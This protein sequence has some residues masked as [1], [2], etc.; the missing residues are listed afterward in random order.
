MTP[1]AWG[2][3][4]GGGYFFIWGDLNK[5]LLICQEKS[6]ISVLLAKPRVK[7]NRHDGLKSLLYR[8]ILDQLPA[9]NQDTE[10]NT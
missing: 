7:L 4:G 6:R 8:G 1:L 5:F 9:I 10:A 2:W 3:S